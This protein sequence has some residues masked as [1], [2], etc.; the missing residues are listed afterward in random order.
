V[1][2]LLIARERLSKSF[3]VLTARNGL[4]AEVYSASR[5][6]AAGFKGYN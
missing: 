1:E 2:L 3:L 4:R 5:S 6:P